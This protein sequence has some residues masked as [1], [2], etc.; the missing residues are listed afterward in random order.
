MNS[1][2]GSLFN[3]GE[4]DGDI[5][6]VC[7]DGQIKSHSFVLERFSPVFK[8]MIAYARSGCGEIKDALPFGME[9]SDTTHIVIDYSTDI[10]KAIVSYMYDNTIENNVWEMYFQS[11]NDFGASILDYQRAL[12]YIEALDRYNILIHKKEVLLNTIVHQL[13]IHDWFKFLA[14]PNISIYDCVRDRIYS[15]V[16][17]TILIPINLKDDPFGGVDPTAYYYKDLIRLYREKIVELNRIIDA[18]PRPA[19]RTKLFNPFDL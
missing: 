8:K 3:N 7:A 11:K 17:N 12:E 13:H 16:K 5:T 18:N 19:K 2:I 6:M 9:R 15:Y 14:I 4:N 1:I 10:T